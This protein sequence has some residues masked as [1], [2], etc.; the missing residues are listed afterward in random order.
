PCPQYDGIQQPNRFRRKTSYNSLQTT[1]ESHISKGIAVVAAYTLSKPEDNYLKQDASGEEWGLATGGRH[2][3]HFLKLTW[4]YELPIGP[5]KAVDVKGVLGRVVGGW[6]LTG[7]H[8]YRSGGT[9]SV[10]DSRMNGAGF[11]IRPDV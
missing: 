6:T 8:D 11:P 3:P 7:I 9:L 5:G 4:I 10:F 2:F 1:L